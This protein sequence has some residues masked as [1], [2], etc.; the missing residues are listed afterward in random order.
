MFLIGIIC[1]KIKT[2]VAEKNDFD[3]RD[4]SNLMAT[5]WFIGLS[6]L[7]CKAQDNQFSG[8]LGNFSTS[9]RLPIRT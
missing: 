1:E 9:R 8:N 2:L 5:F 7:W 3:Y 6:G 4:T